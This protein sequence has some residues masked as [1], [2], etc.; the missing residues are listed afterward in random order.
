[1]SANQ[2]ISTRFSQLILS[3]LV[4]FLLLVVGA[5]T[6]IE[7]FRI[8]RQLEQDLNA[9]ASN[10]L[11]LLNFQL[12]TQ[13]RA[14]SRTAQS[15]LSINSLI[16]INGG[17]YYF[18]HALEDL[19][20][21]T[22]IE[23]AHLFDY[24]GNFL[25]QTAQPADW[26]NA[27]MVSNTLSMGTGEIML[28]ND[29]FYIVEP[30]VY[31]GAVQGGII[32]RV[33]MA[34]LTAPV[35]ESIGHNYQIVINESWMVSGGDM[36]KPG[37]QVSQQPPDGLMISPFGISVT[38]SEPY[39]ALLKE[40]LSWLTSFSILALIAL[41][42][43]VVI[44]RRLGNK[45]A[46]P[47]VALARE[48]KEGHYPINTL[49]ADKEIATLADAFNQ[50]TQEINRINEQNIKEE[51]LS[52][53]SQVQAIVDTV[54]DS[55]ITI[56]AHGYIATFNPAAEGLF[57]YRAT[58][59]IGQKINIL[60]PPPF[61]SEHDSYLENFMNGKQAKIIG[62]GREVVGMRKDGSIFPAELSV[63]E[64]RV[65][66]NPM[67]TGIIRDITSRKKDEA[68]KNEFV[69]TVSHELRTPLTSIRGALGIILGKF[70]G[71][72][73][74]KTQ[75]MLTLALRN[76]ERLTLLI[77]DI[78]DIEKLESGA[79]LY[80]FNR[81]NLYSIIA[82]SIEDNTGYAKHHQI[83]VTFES[84]SE[85]AYINADSTRMQQVMANLLSNAIKY[86][87][88]GGE[89]N[90]TLANNGSSFRVEITDH[91]AGIPPEFHEHLFT[92]FS[93]ADSSD[94]RRV[95]GTGLGLAIAKSII[96][97]HKGQL[98]FFSVP[99][100]GTTFFFT[101]PNENH[102]AEKIRPEGTIKFNAQQI[103]FIGTDDTLLAMLRTQ[104]SHHA[105]I[106][107]VDTLSQAEHAMTQQ[108][109]DVA[110]VEYPFV[111]SVKTPLAHLQNKQIPTVLL[112][113]QEIDISL[114]DIVMACYEK[115]TLNFNRLK[116]ELRLII[117]KKVPR[118]AM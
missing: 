15:Q 3:L 82:R 42:P 84:D 6:V 95:G 31:Y 63:S 45:M 108:T 32:A 56:D 44:T 38:L 59:V 35:L 37:I 112:T 77:N 23:E 14:V 87:K 79:M 40:T 51:R 67:F 39:S 53:Q 89:V 101:V 68:M 92:R 93:Q 13:Q 20:L 48:V 73:P 116:S 72:L 54:V 21:H 64:M 110:F 69:A 61:A 24:A 115:Q 90:V 98:H 8:Q 58:E 11:Q 36:T 25:S 1:M 49:Q 12:S 114:P 4:I 55:I 75:K 76:C 17:G 81:C 22:A 28:Q 103:L 113:D 60:M 99:K 66:G 70:S 52:G 78:L 65:S 102:A 7:L 29:N 88:S 41:I 26:F 33:N 94:T 85:T 109:F 50:A 100:Q 10:T 118:K 106:V 19:T 62:I 80:H 2:S 86:S 43:A 105:D 111:E 57:G 91:G 96:E 46:W 47:I 104:F 30:I 5:T 107:G 27:L 34:A 71:E 18:E 74:D 117:K 16:D 97:A 83:T 9:D